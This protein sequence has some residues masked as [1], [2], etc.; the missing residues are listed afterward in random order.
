MTEERRDLV[1]RAGRDRLSSWLEVHPSSLAPLPRPSVEALNALIDIAWH[2]S[3]EGQDLRRETHDLRQAARRLK[4]LAHQDPLTGLANRRALEERLR[5]EWDRSVRYARPLAVLM[6]DLDGL[7]EVNDRFGHP[8][9]DALL[10]TAALTMRESLRSGDLA[11]RIGGDEFLVICP[12]TDRESIVL[13][14]DKLG[15]ALREST[16]STRLGQV[17]LCMSI[18]WATASD[19]RDVEDL[20]RLADEALYRNKATV[21]RR[22]H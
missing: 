18:G 4:D 10:Q 5:A 14:A 13:V 16:I 12:E 1:T 15:E 20:M 3:A 7:K 2:A 6:G 9:G 19:A 21:G 22:S 17:N 8:A 11:G